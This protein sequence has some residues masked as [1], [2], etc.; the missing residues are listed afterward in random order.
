MLAALLHRYRLRPQWT[1][2]LRLSRGRHDPDSTVGSADEPAPLEPGPYA[3]AFFAASDLTPLGGDRG[4]RRLGPRPAPPGDG[5]DL[6]PHLRRI[7]LSTVAMVAPDPCEE[8]F[9]PV[10]PEVADLMTSLAAQ[11][12]VEPARPRP[13]RIDGH[14]GQVLQVHVPLDVDVDGLRQTAPWSRG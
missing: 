4:A 5:P 2:S 11:Q 12:T 3:I 8:S 14:V 6:D 9:V 13:A 7:E 1:P 10:G